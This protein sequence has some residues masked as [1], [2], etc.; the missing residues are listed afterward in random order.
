MVEKT[1]RSEVG[2]HPRGGERREWEIFVRDEE[3]DPMRHVGS[4]SAPSPGVAHEQATRLFAW[5]A[6]DVWICPADE[7]HRYSTHQLDD[8]AVPAPH[9]DG[10]EGRTHEL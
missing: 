3:S 1:E 6:E 2:D 5:F 9:P 8:D 10:E 7:M 4:V